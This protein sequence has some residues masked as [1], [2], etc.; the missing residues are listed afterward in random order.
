MKFNIALLAGIISFSV[1]S[2]GTW[3]A[4]NGNHAMWSELNSKS[5]DCA[6]IF[7]TI[8][9][10]TE[11]NAGQTTLHNNFVYEGANGK[12]FV[13][14]EMLFNFSAAAA[15]DTGANS[16]KI[17]AQ[18]TKADAG[19]K[20]SKKTMAEIMSMRPAGEQVPDDEEKNIFS[21]A[22]LMAADTGFKDK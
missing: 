16:Q 19:L 8:F 11:K 10:K 20:T 1:C 4:T 5:P 21:R 2:Y 15:G 9:R 7:R 3:Y 13:D 6:A 22:C 14:S 17:D 12:A 18:L